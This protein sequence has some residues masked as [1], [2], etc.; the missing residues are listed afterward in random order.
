MNDIMKL[1]YEKRT[2]KIT[3]KTIALMHALYGI[4]RGSEDELEMAK[5]LLTELRE[6]AI[7]LSTAVEYMELE[8]RSEE[9]R[10]LEIMSFMLK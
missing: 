2:E 9:M 10:K 6:I 1:N 4:K 7:D 3:D 5:V 8:K